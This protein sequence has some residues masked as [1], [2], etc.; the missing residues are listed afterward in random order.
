MHHLDVCNFY[1][2]SYYT[3]THYLGTRVLREQLIDKQKTI[4]KTPRI[5]LIP[6]Q[7][8][9][10]KK[11]ERKGKEERDDKEIMKERRDES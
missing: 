7:V 8:Q 11:K 9:T 2:S 5:V 4:Y 10:K 1:S 6:L 3:H